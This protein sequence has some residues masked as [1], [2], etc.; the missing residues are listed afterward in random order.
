VK[1]LLDTMLLKEIGKPAPHQNVDAWLDTV[2]DMDLFIS[3]ISV[4]EIWKGIERKRARDSRAAGMIE[5]AARQIFTAFQGR[6]LFVDEA[7]AVRWGK[8]LGRS[9]KNL[10]DTGLTATAFVHGMLL[11]TRN[12]SDVQGRGADVLDPFKKPARPHKA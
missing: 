6:I 8:L 2:D 11:T 1:Y 7:V 5:T 4:R 9:D 3:V 12:V 10:D